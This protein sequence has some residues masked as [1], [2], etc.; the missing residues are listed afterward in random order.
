MTSLQKGSIGVK[1]QIQF[2]DDAGTPINV[3]SGLTKRIYYR[4]PDGSTGY[5]AAAFTTDGTDGKVEYTTVSANDIDVINQWGLQ[6]YYTTAG[7]G[8]FYTE[9]AELTVKANIP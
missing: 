8:V 5:W 4:K 1:I 7:G 3:S 9:P 6:G 2:V